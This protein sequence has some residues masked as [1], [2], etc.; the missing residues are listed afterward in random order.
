MMSFKR[1]STTSSPP[2][3]LSTFQLTSET[4]IF[5]LQSLPNKLC[6]LDPIPTSLLK[7]CESILVPIITKIVNLSL[8]T[9][10]FP[11]LFQHSLVTPLLK[12]PSFDKEILSNYRPVS[13]L[14]FFSKLTERV[15][16]S[17]INDYLTS[18]SLNP[19]QSGFTKRHSTETLLTSLYNK[20][21]SAISHQQVS[22][23]PPR[24]FCNL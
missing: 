21:V 2:V 17:R 10:S 6:K 19:H 7:D 14:S 3:S 13:N 12:K 20:L 9:C 24:Y 8:S 22:C 15:V 4:E 11:L 23:L 5:L 1:H 16:L 18:N